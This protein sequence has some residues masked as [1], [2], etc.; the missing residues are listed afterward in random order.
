MKLRLKAGFT[1]VEMMVAVLMVSLITASIITVSGAALNIRSNELFA[2]ESEELAMTLNTAIGDVLHYSTGV[3]TAGGT[4]NTLIGLTNL[5]Y[6]IKDGAF[7]LKDGR[8]YLFTAADGESAL[9]LV[10]KGTYTN[11]KIKDFDV[12]YNEAENVF[13][14]SYNIEGTKSNQNKSITFVFRPIN[15]PE[16]TL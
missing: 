11:M 6:G 10:S 4:D 5:N 16:A 2:S 12:T 13:E 9:P 15:K 3:K 8:L 14:G 1:A 7:V